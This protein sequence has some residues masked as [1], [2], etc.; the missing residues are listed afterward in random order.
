MNEQE[1]SLQRQVG[2]GRERARRILLLLLLLPEQP[3]IVT[4]HAIS[5]AR[6]CFSQQQ[7]VTHQVKKRK[8][9]AATR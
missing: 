8:M 2:G 6:I 3:L 5:K 1:E 4:S 9:H 7:C